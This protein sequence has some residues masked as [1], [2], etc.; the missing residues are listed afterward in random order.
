VKLRKTV[1]IS[2]KNELVAGLQAELLIP[3]IKFV[4]LYPSRADAMTSS[5]LT[6]GPY[7]LGKVGLLTTDA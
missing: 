1:K 7:G 6:S 3:T 2:N 4:Y 5:I